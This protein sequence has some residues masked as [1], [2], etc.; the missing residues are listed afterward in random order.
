MAVAVRPFNEQAV[1]ITSDGWLPTI[2][3][4]CDNRRHLDHRGEL[5][6]DRVARLYPRWVVALSL[7]EKERLGV[8]ELARVFGLAPGHVSRMLRHTAALLKEQVFADED[9]SASVRRLAEIATEQQPTRWRFDVRISAAAEDLEGRIAARLPGDATVTIT[10]E[11]EQLIQFERDRDTLDE[12]VSSALL[13][14]QQLAVIVVDVQLDPR[15]I[16]S[17]RGPADVTDYTMERL[18]KAAIHVPM[19]IRR[20]FRSRTTRNMSE[21]QIIQ[22]LHTGDLAEAKFHRLLCYFDVATDPGYSVTLIATL[23]PRDQAT[24]RNAWQIARLETI[25]EYNARQSSEKPANAA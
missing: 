11:H 2:L 17:L 14:L 15:T 21:A 18:R 13:D 9:N 6:P 16:K 10:A 4:Q 24:R 19:I 1:E 20:R 22:Q 25:D 12:A 7:F 5:R 8:R 23:A 3:K